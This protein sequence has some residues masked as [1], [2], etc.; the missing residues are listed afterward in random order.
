MMGEGGSM[1]A[2]N[3]RRAIG[4]RIGMRLKARGLGMNLSLRLVALL[5]FG[6]HFF[7]P[8]PAAMAQ[9]DWKKQWEAT[10]DAGRKE[11]EVVIYGP[12]NPAY[13]RIWAIFQKSYPEVKFNFVPG[14]GSDHAQRI[15]AERR[16]G[17]QNCGRP[18]G[19]YHDHVGPLVG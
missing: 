1:N 9:T 8:S 7:M 15:V 2:R 12:H 5:V 13:Q 16:A 19:R 4:N 3:L 18:G 14:K 17:C 6:C 11:G 10:V